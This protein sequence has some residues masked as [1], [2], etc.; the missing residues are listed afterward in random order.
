MNDISNTALVT[1]RCHIQDARDKVALLKDESS[2]KTYDYLNACLDAK[3][4]AMLNKPVGKRLVKHT[5]ARAKKYDDYARS[6]LMENPEGVIVNIGCGLDHR[7]ERVDNGKCSFY[8]LDLPDIMDIKSKIF[9]EKERYKQVGKSVF[10][11]NWIDELPKQPAFLLAE[12]V[13]MFCME[14]D[15]KS[16]FQQIHNKIPGTDMVFEVFS[17]KWLSGWRKKLVDFKLRRQLRFGEDASF[18]FGIADSD[19]IKTWSQHFKL[20]EDWCYVDEIKPNAK[21]WMRKIQ[22]TVHYQIL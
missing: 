22:W 1:L 12:G 16:L 18:R 15:V 6:F 20:I 4:K 10:D 9:H 2:L 17:S 7:F 21:E 8:D 5:A 3:G 19:E 14:K 13:F 11:F